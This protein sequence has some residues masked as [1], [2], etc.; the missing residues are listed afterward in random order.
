MVR[1]QPNSFRYYFAEERYYFLRE[2]IKNIMHQFFG[3][4]KSNSGMNEGYMELNKIINELNIHA[5]LSTIKIEIL[6]MV[7]CAIAIAEA[8]L[9]RKENIGTF[10]NSDLE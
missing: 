5:N 10:Y 3:V 8:S 1:Y 2:R 4:F 6:N 7:T 9:S